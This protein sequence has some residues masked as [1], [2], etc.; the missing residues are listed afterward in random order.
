MDIIIFLVVLTTLLWVLVY[1][2]IM[3]FHLKEYY[4]HQNDLVYKLRY[5]KITMIQ[6]GLFIVK[7]LYDSFYM[8]VTAVVLDYHSTERKVLATINAYLAAFFL[9]SFVWKFWL[10]RYD[11]IM[12]DI[13]LN[14][15]WKSIINPHAFQSTSTFY[16]KHRNRF[17]TSPFVVLVL[18]IM[19]IMFTTVYVVTML[20]DHIADIYGGNTHNTY[21]IDLYSSWDYVIPYILLIII[22]ITMPKFN[23]H[24]FIVQEMKYIFIC[25]SINYICY[26]AH[27]A[28]FSFVYEHVSETVENIG[29]IVI[30]NIWISAQ[31]SSLMVST[32]WVNN[33]CKKLL[34]TRV[35]KRISEE[36]DLPPLK[37]HYVE[38]KVKNHNLTVLDA[39]E[40]TQ[41]YHSFMNCLSKEMSIESLLSLTEFMQFR[42]YV[43][44]KNINDPVFIVE[45]DEEIKD[46][47]FMI[48]LPSDVPMSWIV[49]NEEWDTKHKAFELYNKYIKVGSKLEI[50]I[51]GAQ[52]QHYYEVFEASSNSASFGVSEQKLMCLFDEICRDQVRLMSD[53]MRRFARHRKISLANPNV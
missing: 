43:H 16:L 11:I 8:L 21:L 40:S 24:F 31:F 53:S 26:F 25:L 4:T 22:V 20:S 47:L 29:F 9:Y 50:N 12:N 39:L 37:Q 49:C 33:R 36:Y 23:D 35:P 44:A 42:R 13:V 5:W 18:F 45:N 14:S 15:D 7:L 30:A 52:R 38:M 34:I 2:P 27:L 51:G 17:G 19:S 6:C 3:I 32:Q 41:I 48:E 10:L 28:I 46:S 1:A